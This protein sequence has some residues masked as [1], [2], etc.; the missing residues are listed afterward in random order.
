MVS[1]LIQISEIA[2]VVMEETK[3]T[4]VLETNLYN[5]HLEHRFYINVSLFL[6]LILNTLHRDH[7]IR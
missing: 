3:T 4:T 5:R 6:T 1:C 7:T 2:R